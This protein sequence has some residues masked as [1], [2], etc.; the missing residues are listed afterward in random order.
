MSD[1]NEGAKQSQRGCDQPSLPPSCIQLYATITNSFSTKTASKL[2]T[3]QP[4]SKMVAD[5]TKAHDTCSST[6]Q[7]FTLCRT[8]RTCQERRDDLRDDG[9]MQSEGRV[10]S[11]RRQAS[12]E[13]LDQ[14]KTTTLTTCGINTKIMLVTAGRNETLG[15]NL[16]PRA[17]SEQDLENA[18]NVQ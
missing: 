1:L 18:G 13:L 3:R 7:R 8:H 16:W 6:S 15:E 5:R 2:H 4:S 9:Q 17:L 12:M 11:T 14:S 10:A